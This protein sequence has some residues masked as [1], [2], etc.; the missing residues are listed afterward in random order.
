MKTIYLKPLT[1]LVT[2]NTH[3]EV[4]QQTWGADGQKSN[5]R[6][7]ND[8]ND[9]FFDDEEIDDEYDPFFDD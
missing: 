9:A 4:L 5:D 8:A 7:H 1:E 3:V 2:L 6:D